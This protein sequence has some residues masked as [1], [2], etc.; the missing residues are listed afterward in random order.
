M[1]DAIPDF[2]ALL[3]CRDDVV[4]TDEYLRRALN[5]TEAVSRIVRQ[6]AVA[7]MKIAMQRSVNLKHKVNG[8][9]DLFLIQLTVS[10]RVEVG[11]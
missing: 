2:P 10:F 1:G 11:K 8:L 5:F 6:Q 9:F 7:R 4:L 3:G